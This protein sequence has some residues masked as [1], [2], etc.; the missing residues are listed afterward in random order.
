MCDEWC[1]VLLRYCMDNLRKPYKLVLL[2]KSNDWKQGDLGF[3]LSS[4]VCGMRFRNPNFTAFVNILQIPFSRAA[5]RAERLIWLLWC[6]CIS[7][8]ACL[9]A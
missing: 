1:T 9:L 7:T 2:D 4:E 3:R 8:V 6:L 5:S